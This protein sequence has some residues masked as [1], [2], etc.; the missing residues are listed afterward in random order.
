MM[1]TALGVAFGLVV[2]GGV[3]AVFARNALSTLVARLQTGSMG[4]E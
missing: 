4:G 3:V 2:I 1:R